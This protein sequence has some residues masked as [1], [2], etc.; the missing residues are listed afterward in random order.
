M[1]LHDVTAQGVAPHKT[2]A[3]GA[4]IANDEE[5]GGALRALVEIVDATDG[6]EEHPLWG[7]VAVARRFGVPAEVF[8]DFSAALQQVSAP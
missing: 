1:N 2:P 5:P 3:F 8:F 4:P 6:R 7:T